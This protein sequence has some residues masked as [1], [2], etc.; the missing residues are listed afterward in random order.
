[1]GED[2][3]P[4]GFV[5]GMLILAGLEDEEETK[6][7]TL[8]IC[9]SELF[10]GEEEGEFEDSEDMP[11]GLDV[12]GFVVE[13]AEEAMLVAAA[14]TAGELPI[15]FFNVSSTSAATQPALTRAVLIASRETPSFN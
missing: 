2:D 9:G 3:T 4:I 5:F 11:D 13:A 7:L 10:I 8:I 6:S 12:I 1:M 15:T 14:A